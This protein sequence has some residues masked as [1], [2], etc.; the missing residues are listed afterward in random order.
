MFLEVIKMNDILTK[1]YY[2][3]IDIAN[4][5]PPTKRSQKEDNLYEPQWN[6]EDKELAEK[7]GH[8][9]GDFFVIK[10]FFDCIRENRKPQFDEH[11]ATTCSSVAILSHRSAIE[12]G[13]PYDI[14]DFRKEKDCL[15][16]EEDFL[17]PIP[18]SDG[19][20]PDMPCCSHPDYK[21]TPEQFEAY[22][23][24]IK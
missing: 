1:L 24:M 16:Y 23:E 10:E 14:P 3:Q 15:K 5:K 2:G 11:F 17:T 6:V 8:G 9:G 4:E 22:L 18:R 19:K 7:A 20:A 21:P 13:I 12:K